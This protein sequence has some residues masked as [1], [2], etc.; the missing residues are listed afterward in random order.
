MSVI[1]GS[2]RNHIFPQAFIDHLQNQEWKDVEQIGLG[3]DLS[4]L[5][6]DYIR[7]SKLAI[8]KSQ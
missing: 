2:G 5:W 8:S 4:A 6:S 3:E 7:A 1:S